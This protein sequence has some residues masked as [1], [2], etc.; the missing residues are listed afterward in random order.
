MINPDYSIKIVRPTGE[1]FQLKELQ[2]EVQGISNIIQ[3]IILDTRLLSM[4]KGLLMR[5]PMNKLSSNI[6]GI[7][8]VGNVVIVPKKLIE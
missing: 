5:L 2:E 3:Q 8:A 4:K 1:K 6:F 7:H